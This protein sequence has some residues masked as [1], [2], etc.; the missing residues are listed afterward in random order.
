M[1]RGIE[2]FREQF[3]DYTGQYVFIGGTACDIILGRQDVDFRVT[4]DFDIV[5]V[6]E[7][8]DADFINR[9]VSFITDGGYEHI[10]KGTGENQ[11][12]RFSNPSDSSFPGMIEL[13]SRRPEYL[14]TI[15]TQLS[16]IHISDDTV[17]LSAILLDDEYYE[18]LRNGAI[19]VEG[20]SVL[21]IEYLILFKMKAWLDLSWRKNRGESVDSKSIKKHKNDVIRLAVNM[22]LNSKLDVQGQ[23]KKDAEAFLDELK[24]E[25]VDLRSLGI[26]G[27]SIDDII[28]RMRE[29][30]GIG[31]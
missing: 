15:D 10:N 13:F 8:L 11:F 25:K 7:A 17:S 29:C 2:V 14:N 26:R 23:I 31:E 18:L 4:K 12:Y 3:A 9:F 27:V 19:E 20:V 24:N 1:V 21:D 22:P 5:L 16:P 28:E 30:Y 6:I